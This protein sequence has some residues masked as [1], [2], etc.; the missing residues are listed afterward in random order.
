MNKPRTLVISGAMLASL[1]A[2]TGCGGGSSNATDVQTEDT[3]YASLEH[4]GLEAKSLKSASATELEN[5]L[6][7][8][9]RLNVYIG[10][11]PE[12]DE[13]TRDSESSGP[14]PPDSNDAAEALA[15]D[16]A[17]SSEFSS[18]NTHVL[19]VDESDFVKY[20]GRYLY[21]V[22]NPEYTWGQDYPTAKIRIMETDPDNAAIAEL[23]T[24]DV[25]N[26]DWG[27][28]GELY[29]VS[30][31]DTETDLLVTLRSSWNYIAASEPALLDSTSL[32]FAPQPQENRIQIAGYSVSD[33]SNPEAAFNIE[34]TG[35][36]QSS[37]KIGDTLYLVTQYS[38]YLPMIDYYVVEGE[39]AETNEKQIA[40]LELDELLPS[41][42]FNG[43]EPQPLVEASD[44]YIPEETNTNAGYQSTISLIAI[45]LASQ[46]LLSASCFNGEVNG[47]YASNN[48]IYL[49]GSSYNTGL[50]REDDSANDS[51]TVVH[52]FALNSGDI[53]YQSTAVVPGE[54]GWQNPS[55]RMDEHN[56][57]L[58]IVTTSRDD[59]W[60]PSHNLFIL[61]DDADSSEMAIVSTLPNDN[62]PEKIGKP[63]EDIYAVR[64]MEDQAYIVT[65]ERTDPLY[66][67]NLQDAENPVIAGEL[68]VPGF[69]TY[70]HPVDDNYLLGIGNDALDTGAVQGIKASLYDIRDIS[71]PQEITSI[72][73]GDRGTWSPALYDLR[74]ITFLRTSDD[75]LRFSFPLS[76][77]N[78]FGIVEPEPAVLEEESEV[79]ET[80]ILDEEPSDEEPVVIDIAAPEWGEEALQLFE[81]NGLS[82]SSASLLHAGKIVS[83]SNDSRSYPLYSGTDRSV[84]HGE[85]VYYTHGENVWSA[86][87]NTPEAATGPH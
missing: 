41:I 27:E 36:L 47:I 59:N 64:F 23:S 49:G 22:T 33:A 6:K 71:A 50:S 2:L 76:T 85:A 44:C 4:S 29:L 72:T 8:G 66:V 30:G 18:T 37:R 26:S 84:L 3:N 38:P 45:D 14:F 12:N 15:S 13:D 87:W 68:E 28:V 51:F 39:E 46:S 77:Y 62:N 58:R 57:T 21:M 40:E 65:F 32:A 24:I 11:A 9:I 78:T 31:D 80:E 74:A 81:I 16:S 20:D 73:L 56:D 52:K 55:F 43:G 67:L 61:R 19:G 1:T 25:A 5:H 35:Y 53:D 86:F 7:N 54:L 75:Q 70:L 17:S 82:G 83:E 48:N 63:D 79:V 34:V 69:S 60:S 42:S 10:E